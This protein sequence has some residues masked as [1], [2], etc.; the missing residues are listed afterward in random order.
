MEQHRPILIYYKAR[1]NCQVIRTLLLFI[2]VE[3]EE[4]YVDCQ[5]NIPYELSDL[6]YKLSSKG[7]PYLIHDGIVLN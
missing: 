4:V 3:F 2:G 6:G 7:I 5:G 1:G